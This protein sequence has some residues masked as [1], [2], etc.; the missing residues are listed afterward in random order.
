MGQL[1]KGT[2]S[3]GFDQINQ[4]EATG[5]AQ[6]PF[7]VKAA[8]AKGPWMLETVADWHLPQFQEN[9]LPPLNC[10]LHLQLGLTRGCLPQIQAFITLHSGQKAKIET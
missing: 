7:S 10:R 4:L 6:T 5:R 8:G 2:A 9:L 1:E 3:S